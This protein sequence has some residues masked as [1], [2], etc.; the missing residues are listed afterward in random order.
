VRQFRI[1]DGVI[2]GAD[3]EASDI[4]ARMQI[5][6]DVHAG[7]DVR[8]DKVCDAVSDSGECRIATGAVN[9]LRGSD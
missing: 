4:T 6:D 5:E 7:P 1:I 8:A 3:R 2:V 9:E